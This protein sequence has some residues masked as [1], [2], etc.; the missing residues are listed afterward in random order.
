MALIVEAYPAFGNPMDAETAARSPESP[1]SR[2]AS[3]SEPQLTGATMLEEKNKSAFRSYQGL[4]S[5][6]R[7]VSVGQGEEPQ[8]PAR[9]RN[10]TGSRGAP[11]SGVEPAN[12]ASSR[13][14]VPVWVPVSYGGAL[15]SG[16]A[17]VYR[18]GR[19]WALWAMSVS[20]L[21]NADSPKR[22]H[23]D[24]TSREHEHEEH[25]SKQRTQRVHWTLVGH[26]IAVSGWKLVKEGVK[27]FVHEVLDL[28]GRECSC[29]NHRVK[30]L[31][32]RPSA[33]TL[34]SAPA[35]KLDATTSSDLPL[36]TRLFLPATIVTLETK[37][38]LHPS[39]A[40]FHCA[41]TSL[42]FAMPLSILAVAPLHSIDPLLGLAV[43]ASAV[44]ALVSASYHATLWRIL[45]AADTC[46]ATVMA[47]LQTIYLLSSH[48]PHPILINPLTP[49]FVSLFILSIFIYSWERTAKLAVQLCALCMPF[50]AYAYFM[51]G[52]PTAVVTGLLG[53][54]CFVADRKGWAPTHSLWHVLG[55]ASLASGIWAAWRAGN[56]SG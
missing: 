8:S 51:V 7:G 38:A 53:V 14:W 12:T 19:S 6:S 56:A 47:Y 34:A 41:W 2:R 18:R 33:P 23:E 3:M 32:S 10:R 54:G 40:E 42:F 39:I 15:R 4:Q 16:E 21:G 1:R 28:I 35:S 49:L 26:E 13:R 11:R 44:T 31:P 27:T 9:S 29:S 25:H 24:D 17:Q 45:S 36:S 30:R 37:Y 48:H 55:G 22:H 20:G 43:I 5:R 50:L 46:M 52:S